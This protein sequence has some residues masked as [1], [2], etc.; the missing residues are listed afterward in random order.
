MRTNPGGH[1]VEEWQLGHRR[2][3]KLWRDAVSAHGCWCRFMAQQWIVCQLQVWRFLFSSKQLK[4]LSQ[5]GRRCF[6]FGHFNFRDLTTKCPLMFGHVRFAGLLNDFIRELTVAQFFRL[7]SGLSNKCKRSIKK[8]RKGLVLLIRSYGKTV[9]HH[10]LSGRVQA[11]Q[12]L[13]PQRGLL[14]GSGTKAWIPSRKS[15]QRT[16]NQMRIPL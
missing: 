6:S 16:F 4:E 15:W 9:R 8:H 3:L 13:R 12:N 5:I 7:F 14:P 2:H 11:F 10:S 1:T